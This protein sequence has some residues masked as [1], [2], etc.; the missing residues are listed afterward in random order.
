MN[1]QNWR[2][3]ICRIQ[4]GYILSCDGLI[5]GGSQKFLPNLDNL[6]AD[7]DT[8]LAEMTE[9]EKERRKA[10]EVERASYA[11]MKLGLACPQI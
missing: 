2:M 8:Y 11:G 5:Y 7:I 6:K 1:E 4:N 3:V 10:S 9:A